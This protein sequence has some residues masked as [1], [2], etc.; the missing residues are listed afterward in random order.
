MGT[1]DTRTGFLEGNTTGG[2]QDTNNLAAE[3]SLESFDVPHR[4]VLNYSLNLPIGKGQKWLGGA[5]T[6]LNRVIGGWRLSGITTFQSGYPIAL[7]A[8]TNDLATSFGAGGVAPT[9]SRAVRQV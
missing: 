4:L 7:S 1:V 3:R 5:G 2:I 6:G 8:Q 9:G